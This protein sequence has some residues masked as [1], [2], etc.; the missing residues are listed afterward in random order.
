MKKIFI[1]LTDQ[2]LN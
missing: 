1:S 2:T